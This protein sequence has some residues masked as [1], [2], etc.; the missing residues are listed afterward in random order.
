MLS[1]GAFQEIDLKS[2]FN[3]DKE[4]TATVTWL[5]VSM[6]NNPVLAISC[7]TKSSINEQK[8]AF[9]LLF[10]PQRSKVDG[11]I[12]WQEIA[13]IPVKESI[14]FLITNAENRDIFAG[15]S[16]SGDLYIWNYNRTASSS[17]SRIDEIFTKSSEESIAGISFLTNNCLVSCLADG[18]MMVYKVASKQSCVVDKTLKIEQTKL[19]DS[20][21]TAIANINGTSDFI[22]GLFNGKLFLCTTNVSHGS[23][24]PVIRELN[25]HK[26]AVKYLKHCQMSSKNYIASCDTSSE[27]FIHEIDEETEKSTLKLVIKLPLPMKNSLSVTNNMEYILCPLTNGSLEIFSTMTNTR[28][29]LEGNSSGT[30]TICELSKNE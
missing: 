6:Q 18:N 23:T 14:D 17:T 26:F 4:I 20:T 7:S 8:N 15:A 2:H 29:T 22:V 10:E 1:I 21:I 12:Y 27:I 9:L 24:D 11:N 16:I 13:S 3:N 25:S 19:K 28:R 30:G 5:S